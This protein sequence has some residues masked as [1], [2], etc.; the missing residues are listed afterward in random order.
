[1]P[2]GIA[3]DIGTN[4]WEILNG[5]GA[6]AARFDHDLPQN[7]NIRNRASVTYIDADGDG[8]AEVVQPAASVARYMERAAQAGLLSEEQR[9]QAFDKIIAELNEAAVEESVERQKRLRRLRS[10]IDRLDL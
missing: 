4:W 6:Q 5:A 3:H 9:S 10:A 1:M 2:Q 8:I 7:K